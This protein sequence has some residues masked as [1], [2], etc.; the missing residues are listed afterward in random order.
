MECSKSHVGEELSE[1]VLRGLKRIGI[2]LNN[3]INEPSLICMTQSE[4]QQQFFVAKTLV[5]ENC[6]R[7]Y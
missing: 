7:I 6:L 1:I 5:V 2:V 3:R 4:V